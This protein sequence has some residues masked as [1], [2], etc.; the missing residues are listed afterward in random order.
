MM[1][2]GIEKRLREILA[3]LP[4]E[5][6]RALLDFAEYLYERYT[7]AAAPPLPEPLDIPRP[8]SE[9]VVAAIKR[10]RATYPMLDATQ[11]LDETSRLMA[12]HVMRGR[13]AAE[14][15]DELEILFRAH[16]E[17]LSERQRDGG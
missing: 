15:I 8:A 7:R 1:A 3:A 10:L 6:A 13:A 17:R 9:S 16:Y 5:Q 2:K 14:V 11:L 12:E 4:E